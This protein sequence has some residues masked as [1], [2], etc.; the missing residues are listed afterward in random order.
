MMQIAPV[1]GRNG[2]GG[3]GWEAA[4]GGVSTVLIAALCPDIFFRLVSTSLW[5][6]EMYD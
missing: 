4:T 6:W 3:I 5:R 2:A 1:V